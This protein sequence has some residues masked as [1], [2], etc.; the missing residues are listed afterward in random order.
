MTSL[1][2]PAPL[3]QGRNF[4][5]CVGYAFAKTLVDNV[6]NK[7]AVPFEVKDVLGA[8]KITCPC[9]EGTQ[10]K[11][12]CEQFND[13]CKNA[14]FADIDNRFRYR[15]NVRFKRL[16]TI[17][18]AYAQIKKASGVLL[19]LVAIKTGTDGHSR[20]A[21]A[22][23]KAYQDNN[24]MRGLNSWGA[25][26]PFMDITADNF[27]HAYLVDPVLLEKKGRVNIGSTTDPTWGQR[28]VPIPDVTR[29]YEEMDIA[30]RKRKR[31]LSGS[32][33]IKNHKKATAMDSVR[34]PGDC[35]TLENAVRRVH[36]DRR[37]TTIILGEGE[38]QID[39]NYVEISS[40]MNIEGDP[41]VAKEEIVV[42]GGVYFKKGI[43]GNCHLQ[44]LTLRQ[45]K[46]IGVIGVSSFTM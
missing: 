36:G 31:S 25:T 16:N 46:V 9:W 5:T 2:T 8:V 38:H 29:G 6:L 41:G 15:V 10:L 42:L 34:V 4:G 32:Y 1:N 20:H 13:K 33:S 18:E 39:G 40:A 7:Y 44:H 45:A 12:M 14:W 24:E 17:A 37:L 27:L 26:K 19:L 21:L 3:N 23:D 43:Q 22:A 11:T 35:A 28:T 30:S